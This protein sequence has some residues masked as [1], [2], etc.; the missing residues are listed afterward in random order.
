MHGERWRASMVKHYE[1]VLE[2]LKAAE[3]PKYEE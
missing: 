2:R 3:P 1:G